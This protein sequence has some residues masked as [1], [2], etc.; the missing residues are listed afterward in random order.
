M[1]N[2]SVASRH[3]PYKAEEFISEHPHNI[4]ALFR[5]SVL[6]LAIVRQECRT[7]YIDKMTHSGAR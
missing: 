6:C 2:P 5:M 3:L 1:G 7:P 4:L